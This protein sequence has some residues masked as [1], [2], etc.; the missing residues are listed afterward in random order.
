MAT[1][2]KKRAS[3]TGRPTKLT[4]EVVTKLVAAFNMGYN[5]TEAASYAGISRKVYYDWLCRNPDFRYKINRAKLEPTI[6][7]KE[8]LINAI[9]SGN[10]NAAKWWLERKAASE[11]STT[12]DEGFKVP[13]E[14]QPHINTLEGIISI[15]D[16]RITLRYRDH[17]YR[18]RE[19]E[20]VNHANSKVR[21]GS[22]TS[23]RDDILTRLL[24]LPDK[25]LADH[26]IQ[27]IASTGQDVAGVRELIDE[28]QTFE[29]YLYTE[30]ERAK[31]WNDEE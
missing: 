10:L 14:L 12:P 5:D 4:P 19:Q 1:A 29:G 8:V 31:H 22:K 16:K 20:R 13:P 23:L 21:G 3:K 24:Q 9:N 26:I 2:A 11:F 25:E 28:R 27:E 6:K 30:I 18:V 17:I 7:A 15:T